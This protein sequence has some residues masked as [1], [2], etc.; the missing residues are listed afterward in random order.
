MK[1]KQISAVLEEVNRFELRE[2]DIPEIQSDEALLQVEMAGV[3]RTD[4]SF[5]R[6]KTRAH[7]IP[8]I[9]G[10]E[11]LGHIAAI[12]EEAA[13]NYGVREGDRVVV[14]S[15]IR[16]GY[17][18][19]CVSGSYQLCENRRSYG[20]S[21][22]VSAPPHLWGAYGQYMYLAPG[23]GVHRISESVPAE[24][25]VLACSVI[26]NG[27]QWVRHIGQVNIG[28]VVVIQGAGQQGLAA[29]IAAKESGAGL[30]LMTGLTRDERRFEL[31]KTLG[32]DFTVDVEK[33]EAEE[34]VRELTQGAMADVLLDVTGSPSALA[35]AV[36]LVRKGGCI[37]AASV[38]GDDALVPLHA[39][40][41]L[42]K[43]ITL[44]FVYTNND[45]A[46]RAAIQLIESRKYP[47]EE[48]VTDR[49]KLGEAELAVQTVAGDDSQNYPIKVAIIP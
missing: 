5:Y 11:I 43:Q 1:G 16:C 9:L 28:D 23:S 29:T 46:V 7:L 27:I 48:M 21:M 40:Q 10:H 4:A 13:Q 8:L 20:T 19:Y 34:R 31:A 37:V 6:G 32:A 25:A 33:E 12:G 26:A 47:L 2:L 45:P 17:C 44:K 22:P 30:I 15:S 3:C 14:E 41:L 36:T 38:L 35:E 18:R 42:F 24:A 39:D 49:F